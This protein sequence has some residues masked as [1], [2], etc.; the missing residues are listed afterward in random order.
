[1][2]NQEI[3]LEYTRR[4]F[5]EMVGIPSPSGEEERIRSYLAGEFDR[6]GLRWETDRA[7]AVSGYG[8]DNIFCRIGG[9]PTPGRLRGIAF[10]SHLDTVTPAREGAVV[11]DG[12]LVRTDGTS[13][14]GADDKAGVALMLGIAHAVSRGF[15]PPVPLILC[16]TA[17]EEV[18]L[19][20]SA[21]I[22]EAIFD[23][24][25]GIVLDCSRDVGCVVTAGP[26]YQEIVAG[27]TGRASHAGSKP[28]EG[29][30]AHAAAARA[31]LS[32]E[33][34]RLDPASTR[35][36]IFASAEEAT[37]IIPEHALIKGEIRS[38][39]ENTLRQYDAETRKAFERTAQET[40][41]ALEWNSRYTFKPFRLDHDHPLVELCSEAAARRGITPRCVDHTGASDANAL[42]SKGIASV[43]LG[44][45]ISGCHSSKES[46]DMS[47]L[48]KL[49]GIVFEI[50]T[51]AAEKAA[52]HRTGE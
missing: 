44:L 12:D 49:A 41:V 39:D 42:N 21:N 6:L 10:F 24:Y 5:L 48:D 36:L 35:N 4:C 46:F 15:T 52:G 25:D 31:L 28:E 13:I 2:T 14:L 29:I 18:G 45:G 9:P 34:G 16:F 47:N 37:N 3:D 11:V 20:G 51:L 8:F 43:N 23:G 26:G 19:H 7:G 40:G 17:G 33:L 27:F 38:L 50:I 30:H 1:M 32:V 22:D